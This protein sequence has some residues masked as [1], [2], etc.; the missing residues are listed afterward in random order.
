MY[1]HG[2]EVVEK[3]TAYE[4][5]LATQY[6][7][8]VLVGTAPVNLAETGNVNK[9]VKVSNWDEAVKKL[10]YSEDWEKYTLCQSMVACFQMFRVYSVIF[11]NVL[12]PSKHKKQN[13]A[14]KRY[15]KNHGNDKTAGGRR[16]G[17]VGRGLYSFLRRFGESDC[18]TFKHGNTVFGRNHQCGKRESGSIKSDRRRFDW[19]T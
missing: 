12:D 8:Q 4:Q 5:P 9:P 15:L 11:I 13:E 18:D 17:K 6:G 1:K 3:G 19:R 10:G 14:G 2:I 16:S 7:V